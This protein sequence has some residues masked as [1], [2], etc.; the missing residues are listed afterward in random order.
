MT[1]E[2]E[3][4]ALSF[5]PMAPYSEHRRGERIKYRL[6]MEE[7]EYEGVIVWAC[8]GLASG[9]VHYIVLRDGA[10]DS[11]PDIVFPAYVR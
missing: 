8:A 1:R 5:G 10:G 6:P 11:F 2:E 4:L 3:A 7:G 9:R